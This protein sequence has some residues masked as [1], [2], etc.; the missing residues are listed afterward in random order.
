M[1]KRWVIK[2]KDKA[3]RVVHT[4]EYYTALG[5]FVHMY[6]RVETALTLT[7]WH[8]ARLKPEIAKIAF[9]NPGVEARITAITKMAKVKKISEESSEDL[10]DVFRQLRAINTA[11]NSILHFGATSIANGNAIVSNAL[12][13]HGEPTI[14]PVSPPVLNLMTKDCRKIIAH[15]NYNHL[16]KSP[17]SEDKKQVLAETLQSPW[18]YKYQQ[19]NK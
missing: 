11:R 8:Y 12:K 10:E 5:R 6:A 4:R 7:L 14:F 16:G 17:L 15:L 18:L 19:L 3:K 13:A 9:Y 2:S 1:S